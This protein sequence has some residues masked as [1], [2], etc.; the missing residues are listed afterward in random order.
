[1]DPAELAALDAMV[2]AADAG[3]CQTELVNDDEMAELAALEAAA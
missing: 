1:M 3:G 2:A